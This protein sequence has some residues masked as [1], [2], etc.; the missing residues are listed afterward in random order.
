M[1]DRAS[2]R[3]DLEGTACAVTDCL[4]VVDLI[5]AATAR[6]SHLTQVPEHLAVITLDLPLCV[7]HAHGLCLGVK[8]AQIDSRM[9]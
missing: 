5:G 1:A 8:W 6:I 7:P 9:P 2:L 3:P 4:L